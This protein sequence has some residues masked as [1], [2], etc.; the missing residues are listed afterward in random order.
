MVHLFY[1]TSSFKALLSLPGNRIIMLFACFTCISCSRISKLFSFQNSITSLQNIYRIASFLIHFNPHII[2][3][4]AYFSYNIFSTPYNLSYLFSMGSST[5]FCSTI[6]L[7]FI[8]Y[9]QFCIFWINQTCL[10]FQLG[11]FHVLQKYL[12]P[13]SIFSL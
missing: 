3:I 4:I 1:F 6:N 8:I 9:F 10:Q 12:T 13:F 11:S 2:M 5:P 7:S